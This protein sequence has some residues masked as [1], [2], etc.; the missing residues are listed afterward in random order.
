MPDTLSQ[1][2]I[3]QEL[4]KLSGWKLSDDGKS[5]SKSFEFKDFKHAFA[6]MTHVALIAEKAN[7]HPDWSNVYNKLDVTLSTHDAGGITERDISLAD[8]MDDIFNE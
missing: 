1:E 7:H 6:F 4:K 3:A 2:T 5:I 8:K